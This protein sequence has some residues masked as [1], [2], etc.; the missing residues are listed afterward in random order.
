MDGHDLIAWVVF[1]VFASLVFIGVAIA[2]N[3][4]KRDRRTFIEGSMML[5]G[6]Y[7][8]AA[9]W[10]IGFVGYQINP[11]EEEPF[12]GIAFLVGLFGVFLLVGPAS[13]FELSKIFNFNRARIIGLCLSFVAMIPLLI[14]GA[15]PIL[16]GRIP[17]LLGV[18]VSTLG[19]AGLVSFL[20]ILVRSYA[21][22]RNESE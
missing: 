6:V 16:S 13:A 3:T 22:E 7:I 2:G 5:L 19:L 18:V 8:I 1:G 21:P 4:G 12:L 14:E 17:Y 20:V 9:A 15:A 10:V 11:D